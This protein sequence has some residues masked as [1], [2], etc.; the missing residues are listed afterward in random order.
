MVVDMRVVEYAAACRKVAAGAAAVRD[1]LASTDE[2]I[3][4]R[5]QWQTDVVFVRKRFSATSYSASAGRQPFTSLVKSRAVR[6]GRYSIR[7]ASVSM[8]MS[9]VSP[10][11]PFSTP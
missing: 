8:L 1:Y 7:M 10:T 5:F 11:N 2:R 6:L 9:I 3:H 4:G